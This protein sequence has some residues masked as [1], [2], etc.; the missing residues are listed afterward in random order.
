MVITVCNGEDLKQRVDGDITVGGASAQDKFQINLIGGLID[1]LDCYSRLDILNCGS[2]STWPGNR[3]KYERQETWQKNYQN[4]IVSIVQIATLNFPVL[5][6]LSRA[7]SLV[8]NLRK[9]ASENKSENTAVLIY[10]AYLPALLAAKLTRRKLKTIEII[11]DDPLIGIDHGSKL[12]NTLFHAYGL[13]TNYLSKDKDGY[14]LFAEGMAADAT[15]N[16]PCIIV[17]GMA[18]YS[19]EK[20]KTENNESKSEIVIC[21][22]GALYINNE[23]A[24]FS[25]AF[26]KINDNQFELWI[27]GD[28]EEKA[29][30][31]QLTNLN[32]KI[33]YYGW[34]SEKELVS[35]MRYADVMLN[36]RSSRSLHTQFSFPSKTLFYMSKEKPVLM[37]HLKAIPGEYDS[38]LFY[39]SENS[40]SDIR[41]ALDRLKDIGKSKLRIIGKEN[42]KWVNE[43]KNPKNTAKNI[44]NFI[45]KL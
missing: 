14:V 42:A 21:Y 23:V 20:N 35:V 13:I 18:D 22:A 28:G 16:K 17:E 41:D 5:K 11:P 44:I 7:V 15:K 40:E 12:K 9:I 2:Y 6:Q 27:C 31:V 39:Y 30:I 24:A 32:P 8:K 19:S 43:N 26:N 4:K 33:K 34:L 3:I 10:S 25:R 37:Q 29:E 1:N 36:P 45:N 38:H